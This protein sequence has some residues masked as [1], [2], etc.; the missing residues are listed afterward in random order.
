MQENCH[1]RFLIF[2][3]S[4]QR[5]F[6]LK[7]FGFFKNSK[8]RKFLLNWPSN[9]GCF[10]NTPIKVNRWK[11]LIG[12]CSSKLILSIFFVG[13][14]V[15]AQFWAIA[16]IISWSVKKSDFLTKWSKMI[17]YDRSAIIAGNPHFESPIKVGGC[18]TKLS[19]GPRRWLGKKAKKSCLRGE[20][21]RTKT[22][23][24]CFFL[25]FSKMA[26]LIGKYLRDNSAYR[27]NEVHSGK[28]N[29]KCKKAVISDFLFLNFRHR[30]F[31]V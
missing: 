24:F 5:F 29:G 4:S 6:D 28:A 15:L 25:K 26:I 3:L 1:L 22:P 18:K 14:F 17:I 12:P 30:D 8:R 31:L 19:V 9:C 2:E 23:I 7:F 21:C 27:K 10:L 16:L 20:F 13:R 11:T